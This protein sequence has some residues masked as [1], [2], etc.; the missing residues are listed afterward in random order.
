MAIGDFPWCGLKLC[1]R[2]LREWGTYTHGLSVDTH[3]SD[4][5]L[6]TAKGALGIAGSQKSSHPHGNAADNRAVQPQIL[7]GVTQCGVSPKAN[8]S[9]YGA[10][11]LS[12]VP[13]LESQ[14]WTDCGGEGLVPHRDQTCACSVAEYNL[15]QRP[16][17]KLLID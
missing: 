11:I 14:P 5:F 13:V 2:S 8:S 9:G 12:F 10:Y 4:G 7:E 3:R 15:S 16:H 6:E 17:L 1:C